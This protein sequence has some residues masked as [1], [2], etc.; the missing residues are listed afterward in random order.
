ME[1]AGAD[2]SSEPG[3]LGAALVD[4][5]LATAVVGNADTVETD[6]DGVIHRPAAIAAIDGIG[7]I[8][9]GEVRGEALLEPDGS[10]PFGIRADLDAMAEAVAAA[11]AAAE[12]VVVDTGDTDRAAEYALVSSSAASDAARLRAL[13]RA[14]ELLARVAAEAQPGT[15]L[16][17]VGM[18]PVTTEW[19]LTPTVAWGAGVPPGTTLHSASTKREGLVTLTDV[20]PTILDALG[21]E[22][23]DGMI[24][25]PF[26]FHEETPDLDALVEMDAHAASREGVYYPMAV[27]FIVVQALVYLLA[28][29]VLSQ[30]FGS[31]VRGPLRFAVL[32]FAAWPLATFVE[33]A[34]PGIEDLGDGRQAL[35]WVLAAAIAA[36]AGRARRH[37]LS[38]LAWIA[39]TTRRPPRR[40]RRHR[41]QP[42]AV[43]GARVL[44]AHGRPVHRL[45]QHR[46]RRARRLRRGRRRAARALRATTRRGALDGGRD[47]RR[48]ARRRH[49]A[50][51]RRRRRRR[52]HDGARLRAHDAGPQR[53]PAVVA[54]GRRSPP[55][56]TV[57]VLAVVIVVDLLRP[58]DARTHLGRFV[59][60]VGDDDG[61]FIDTIQRKWST[62]V[63]LFGRTIWT[64]MVPIAAA[65]AVY[66]LVIARGWRRLL[67]PGSALRAGVVGTLFAGIIGW[68]V[69]DSGVVVSALVFVYLGPYLTLLALD[70]DRTPVLLEAMPAEE[71]MRTRE[72]AAARRCRDCRSRVQFRVR[73]AVRGRWRPATAPG[74]H[75]VHDGRG[76]P[77]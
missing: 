27:T 47:L 48:R 64:W 11:A 30:G 72:R 7:S 36:L 68:L 25:Q 52:A 57:A 60:G 58:E 16:L 35:V 3:A 56:A 50:D 54:M 29:V 22:T 62:N 21:V 39:G 17:V 44:T 4:A 33:R 5:G 53:P 15:L 74:T 20:A 9:E 55:R 63:R 18:T 14:D 61:T 24:G 71:H 34:I 19:A 65:F 10:E 12:L 59:T 26:R 66:V 67:P 42:A 75:D 40:R 8:D 49:L 77:A 6:G 13:A 46:L 31:R 23:P 41:R 76:T 69:N 32:T 70:R 2:V 43:V 38:P 28:V 1:E 73:R 51:P 45:R 37:P